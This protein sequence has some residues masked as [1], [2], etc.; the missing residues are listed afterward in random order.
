MRDQAIS[1]LSR[2]DN[3]LQEA[4][5]N[6]HNILQATIY[7]SD[8]SVKKEF[9]EEWTKWIGP[10]ASAWPPRAGIGVS[11]SEGTLCEV[12]LTAARTATTG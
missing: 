4:G 7:I 12:V 6:K 8:Y 10:E 1:L 11:L 3:I 5:S 9:D 2:L